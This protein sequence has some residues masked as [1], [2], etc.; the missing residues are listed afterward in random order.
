MERTLAYFPGIGFTHIQPTRYLVFSRPRRKM[1]RMIFVITLLTS[2]FGNM[3][4]RIQLNPTTSSLNELGVI[5]VRLASS[6]FRVRKQ[7]PGPD[8]DIGPYCVRNTTTNTITTSIYA[9][10]GFI[11]TQT[12]CRSDCSLPGCTLYRSSSSPP[13]PSYSLLTSCTNAESFHYSVAGSQREIWCPFYDYEKSTFTFRGRV[14]KD[15]WYWLGWGSESDCMNAVLCGPTS[16]Y[17]DA[18]QIDT[19]KWCQPTPL[20][21]YSLPCDNGVHACN[22]PP[23]VEDMTLAIWTSHGYGK[24]DGC[25]ARQV[26]SAL[27]KGMDLF[28]LSSPEWTLSSHISLSGVFP[29]GGALI[30]LGSLLTFFIGVVFTSM[31]SVRIAFFHSKWTV[32][33]IQSVITTDPI[34]WFPG[35]TKTL[36]VTLFRGWI[37]VFQ[38]YELV[39]SLEAVASSAS[40]GTIIT[41]G[42]TD[43]LSSDSVH[44]GPVFLEATDFFGS[45]CGGKNM[46]LDNADADFEVSNVKIS[47]GGYQ[48]TTTTTT[49]T[50]S[51]ARTSTLTSASSFLEVAVSPTDWVDPVTVTATSTTPVFST[52]DSSLIS[53][54]TLS[55]PTTTVISSANPLGRDLVPP[56]IQPAS[57][58]NDGLLIAFIIFII[59]TVIGIGGYYIYRK[60]KRKIKDP[61]PLFDFTSDPVF[62][63]WV[64]P[65]PH[66]FNVSINSMP[67]VMY[68]HD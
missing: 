62:N 16:H 36:M 57:S 27:I 66:P 18:T 58:N 26:T 43:I 37:S 13:N 2:G 45:T 12:Q 38:N 30:L 40:I 68:Y 56:E 46:Y 59:I 41:T 48:P 34:I 21:M 61:Q 65:D 11:T 51:R 60:R 63:A 29:V 23:F 42:I 19:L 28:P 35:E 3:N 9:S 49:T 33:P 44:V 20:G 7:N 54:S 53:S 67:T 25:G 1:K 31:S 22:T 55:V 10:F 47:A 17:F 6:L 39:T 14:Y 4:E 64:T 32:D 8:K 24:P 5:S 50:V 52:T 15:Q